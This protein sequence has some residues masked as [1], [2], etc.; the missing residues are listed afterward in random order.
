MLSFCRNCRQKRLSQPVGYT[1][2][3]IWPPM[4]N[5]SPAFG[6]SFL[7]ASTNLMRTW[8]SYGWKSNF[9]IIFHVKIP[10]LIRTHAISQNSVCVCV[11]VCVRVSTYLPSQPPF[12]PTKDG[13]FISNYSRGGSLWYWYGLR[14]KNEWKESLPY[15]IQQTVHALP[16]SSSCP[17]DT[18]WSSHCGTPQMCLCNKEVEVSN[19]HTGW[20]PHCGTPQ[21]CLC[22][23]E[24]EASNKDTS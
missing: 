8:C 16:G 9:H 2:M 22:N 7:R 21:T 20:S 13:S 11:C 4:A 19:K 10:P 23:K 15:H 12:I 5:S 24:A 3:L 6:N 17:L 14:S 18:G 1:S